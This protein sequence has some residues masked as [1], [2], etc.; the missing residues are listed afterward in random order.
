MKSNMIPR[1]MVRANQWSIVISVL[2]TWIFNQHLFLLIPL[3]SGLSCLL[4]NFHPIMA[5]AKKFLTK[6]FDQYIPED[7][8]Q[9]RFNQ[10]LAVSMLSMSY[11][12][13][14][15]N[16]TILS[17]VFSV[18]VF[19]ASAIAIAGFCLGCYI[20]FQYTL[21]KQSKSGN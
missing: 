6:P 7:K 20:R 10:T 21:Y 16:Y 2:L 4:F 18:M 12:S 17:Y 13:S 3:L 11:L 14:L 1:P 19:M 5:I 15:A 8:D 9:Q